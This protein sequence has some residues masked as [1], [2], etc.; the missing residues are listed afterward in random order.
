[1]RRLRYFLLNLSDPF[2]FWLSVVSFLISLYAVACA[3]GWV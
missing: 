2:G 3:R 1:M